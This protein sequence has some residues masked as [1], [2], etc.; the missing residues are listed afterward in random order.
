MS[1]ENQ[2]E[3]IASANSAKV[4]AAWA[5]LR[6]LLTRGDEPKASD[7]KA[8]ATVMT[9]L[10]LTGDDVLR[11][12]SAVAEAQ[13]AATIAG[14]LL[15]LRAMVTEATS[16][17]AAEC[18]RI[19]AEI[20]SLRD[21]MR[22]AHAGVADAQVQMNRAD[23]AFARLNELVGLHPKLIDESFIPPALRVDPIAEA[24]RQRLESEA[25][26]RREGLAGGIVEPAGD[27]LISKIAHGFPLVRADFGDDT[28]TGSD[29]VPAP[30]T[31][32]LES[33]IRR[34]RDRRGLIAQQLALQ[35]YPVVS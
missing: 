2:L 33:V 9:M 34:V 29:P 20:A 28:A 16:H 23:A 1:V 30:L 5:T 12:R 19:D 35:R 6:E 26:H 8:L 14:Q 3:Q 24:E 10:A 17:C 4:S 13:S 7:S 22:R 11:L 18:A 21:Q 27:E 32:R 15:Q 25:A 31:I